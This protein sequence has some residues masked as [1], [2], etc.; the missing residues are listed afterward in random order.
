[1]GTRDGAGGF[2]LSGGLHHTADGTL[3]AIKKPK[4]V[5]GRSGKITKADQRQRFHVNDLE[6]VP[7]TH[8]IWASGDVSVE[9]NGDATF[10]R[11]VIASYST[12]G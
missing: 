6:L 8:E 12:G 9:L 2:V 11:G 3:H 5:A 4:P 10:L 7:G 1:M